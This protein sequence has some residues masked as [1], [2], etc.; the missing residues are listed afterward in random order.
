MRICTVKNLFSFVAMFLIFSTAHASQTHWKYGSGLGSSSHWKHGSGFGS[1]AH[2]K[3]GSGEGSESHWKYGSG[4]GTLSHWKYGSGAGIIPAPKARVW[5]ERRRR[6]RFEADATCRLAGFPNLR[7]NA[8]TSPTTIAMRRPSSSG[9]AV[10]ERAD[11]LQLDQL[12]AGA[13]GLVLGKID[14]S[15]ASLSSR[16]SRLTVARQPIC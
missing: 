9:P 4:P 7:R 15:D 2:W 3:Y 10:R 6:T 5:R 16:W 13:L 14:Q 11:D 12:A 1:E 8:K